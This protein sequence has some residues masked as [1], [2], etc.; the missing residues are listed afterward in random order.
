MVEAWSGTQAM[1][2][3]WHNGYQLMPGHQMGTY[4]YGFNG[5]E[6][7]TELDPSGNLN[8]AEFWEYDSRSG[9]RWNLD[10]KP[11]TGL[12]PY[13]LLGLN[14]IRNIDFAGDTPHVSTRIFFGGVKAV[15]NI[16]GQSPTNWVWHHDVGV[17]VMQLFPK[18]QHT[19][20]SVFW[21]T[22]HPGGLGGMA[23]WGK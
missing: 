2:D 23:I 12:S 17:G 4:K 14:P 6:R 5:Q 9:R 20:G 7:S 22:M 15:S 18:I 8:T 13:A 3:T 11:E 21:E 19:T 10:P 16:L 1:S